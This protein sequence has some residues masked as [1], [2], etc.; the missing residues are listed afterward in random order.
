M[1]IELTPKA[2]ARTTAIMTALAAATTPPRPGAGRS[3]RYDLVVY[4]CAPAALPVVHRAAALLPPPLSD[5][6]EVR[7]LPEGA[8]L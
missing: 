3:L 6:V 7:D 4:L 5:R 1:E 2:T 8:L